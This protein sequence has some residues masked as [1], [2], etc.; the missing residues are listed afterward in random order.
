MIQV[1]DIGPS[2]PSCY[3][4]SAVGYIPVHAIEYIIEPAHNKTY[5]KTYAIRKDS[6]QPVHL[7][8][9]I[10][11]LIIYAFN[12]HYAIQREINENP[13]HTG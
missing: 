9:L 1:S 10:K 7:S 13:C 6:D 8:S 11:V 5:N 3:V 2:W 4:T 12:S